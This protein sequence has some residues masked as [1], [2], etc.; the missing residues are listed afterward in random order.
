MGQT[1]IGLAFS[2][3]VPSTTESPRPRCGEKEK[4]KTTP[5]LAAAP[6]RSCTD[7]DDDR[8]STP[9]R[10]HIHGKKNRRR[11]IVDTASTIA[12]SAPSTVS[13]LSRVLRAL[14]PFSRILCHAMTCDAIRLFHVCPDNDPS[15]GSPTETLLRLLLPLDSQV[16]SSFRRTGTSR[17]DDNKCHGRPVQGLIRGS[18]QTVRS[19]VATGGVY[20]GQGLNQR[21]LMTRAYWEFLVRGTLSQAPVPITDGAQRFTRACRRRARYTLARPV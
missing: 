11:R 18:H 10:S 3:S 19:V 1:E 6:R 15:A 8:S 21:E 5:R 13:S 20:K 14:A 7:D 16:R 17:H 12:S 2:P 4:A 9:R